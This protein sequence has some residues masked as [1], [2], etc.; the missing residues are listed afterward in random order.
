MDGQYAGGAGMPVTS[1]EIADRGLA[2]KIPTTGEE[3]V[4]WEWTNLE[5]GM[6]EPTP[7]SP[8]VTL[9][10]DEKC[11]AASV[12][13]KILCYVACL[14]LESMESNSHFVMRYD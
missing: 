6:P 5:R 10:L 8:H 3:T 4:K 1:E 9:L 12:V 2:I 7:S 11:I 14:C 13:K